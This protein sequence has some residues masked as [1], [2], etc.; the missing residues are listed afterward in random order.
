VAADADALTVASVVPDVTGLDKHFD[1][2]IPAELAAD[3]AVGTIVRVELH[4]RRIGG[5]V[6][7][8]S[9][10]TADGRPVRSL[11]SIAKVTGLGPAAELFEL[12]EWAS[13]RWAARRIRPFLVT[14]S[15]GRAVVRLPPNRRTH[16]R[17]AP[18]SPATRDLL[19]AGGGVLR[20]APRVDVMPTM[21]A[22]VGRGPTL[23]VAPEHDTVA[24]FAARLRRAGLS[25]AIVPDDWA[26]AA[27]GVDVVIGTRTAAWAPCPDL[28]AA[29]VVDEHDEALQNERTPTWHAR[30]VIAE[31]CRLAGV[32][33]V[34]VSPVPTLSAVV[35]YA[36]S[37]GV[38]HPPRARERAG[39][40]RVTVVDRTDE[41]P[42]KRSLVTSELIVRLRD[43]DLTV[44]CVS[45]I[46]GRAR[47]LACRSCRS[48]I[49][50]ERCDAAVGL[51]DDG[52]LS[53]RRCGTRR[54]AV[55]QSCGASRFAN[56]R[57]GVTR[58]REELEAAAARPVV[59]VTGS[60]AGPPASSGV[61]VG[62]EAVLHRIRAA[63]VVAFLEFDSEMLAPRFRASEQALA[64]IVRGGRI[65][66]EVVVQTFSPDHDVIAAATGGDPARILDGER[67]RRQQ[68]GLPPFG[69]LALVSGTGADR[70]VAQLPE[71]VDVGGDGNDRFLVRAANWSTLG[72]ALNAAERPAGSRIRVEMDPARI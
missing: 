45:N 1:Y 46:T 53:C 66:P 50:C 2:L 44:V 17:P 7:S 5:W 26:A 25:V 3:V 59:A 33:F 29:V 42:W 39:W 32:P 15:P 47:V 10:S 14:A 49:R 31:R 38:V 37:E 65:A 72:A 69:A 11:K 51:D 27:G 23:V 60:D 52:R 28:A 71:G 21:L 68:L 63:D 18:V 43:P 16:T 8:I 57:P 41:D 20:L 30:D 54:P 34:L 62:T 40:P 36:G 24:L 35:D 70:L 56:L 19:A 4:G 22:A 9:S 67:A 55:C 58:L 64:L 48:L 13:V 61:Y 6:A 12:A